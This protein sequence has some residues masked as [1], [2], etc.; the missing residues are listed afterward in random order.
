M[1]SIV[2]H[3][4]GDRR[5]RNGTFPKGGQRTGDGNFLA[6]LVCNTSCV[7]GDA[8]SGNGDRCDDRRILLLI[9]GYIHRPDTKPIGAIFLK[10]DIVGIARVVDRGIN[11]FVINCFRTIIA[12]NPI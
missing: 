4:D 11:R 6:S 9:A 2:S 10:T 1:I 8:E 5:I 12:I 3:I 7:D